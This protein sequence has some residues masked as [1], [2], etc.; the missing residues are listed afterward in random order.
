MEKPT[1]IVDFTKIKLQNL[2]DNSPD[3]FKAEFYTFTLEYY[4][5]GAI[6]IEW[7]NGEPISNI[8]H[9][10]FEEY[11]DLNIAGEPITYYLTE[12]ETEKLLDSIKYIDESNLDEEE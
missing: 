2:I 5:A 12:E 3:E 10:V 8:V 6:T 11:N 7:E 1:N 4:E 9:G